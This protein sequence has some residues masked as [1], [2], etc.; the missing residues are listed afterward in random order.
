MDYR[1][2]VRRL[3]LPDGVT[4][5]AYDREYYS[6]VHSALRHWLAN[7]L[8]FHKPYFSNRRIPG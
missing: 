5:S 1:Q 7:D 2:L 3:T 4:A 6:K 8:P